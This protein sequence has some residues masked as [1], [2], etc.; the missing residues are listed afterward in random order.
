MRSVFS[1]ATNRA[2]CRTLAAKPTKTWLPISLSEIY[3]TRDLT[4]DLTRKLI[5]E[6]LK[7]PAT[8]YIGSALRRKCNFKQQNNGSIKTRILA[9]LSIICKRL[10]ASHQ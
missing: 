10:P 3:L 4:R 8:F 7:S 1:L 6:L 5:R 2:F 9:I